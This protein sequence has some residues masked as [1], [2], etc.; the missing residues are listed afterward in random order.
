MSKMIRV[1]PMVW[2][3]RKLRSVDPNFVI[4]NDCRIYL[5]DD[6]TIKSEYIEKFEDAIHSVVR[7]IVNSLSY[8]SSVEHNQTG[9]AK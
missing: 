3:G 6:A 1:Y 9:G 2:R 4:P 7:D 8:Q 5:L